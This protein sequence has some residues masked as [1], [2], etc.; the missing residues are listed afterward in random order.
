M[1]GEP[2]SLPAFSTKK[3]LKVVFVKCKKIVYTLL[4]DWLRRTAHS[5]QTKGEYCI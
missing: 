2:L 4:I 3:T 1:P 5:Y